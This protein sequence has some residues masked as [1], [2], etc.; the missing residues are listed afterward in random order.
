MSDHPEESD[1][2]N[3]SHAY[4]HA[5]HAV[6]RAVPHRLD[7]TDAPRWP[8]NPQRPAP[9]RPI[10][11]V[12]THTHRVESPTKSAFKF[13]F[14]FAAGVWTFRVLVLVVVWTILAIVVGSLV[15]RAFPS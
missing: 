12:V 14:G 1:F 4:E 7:V 6:D 15:M 10:Q 8:A 5:E 13:G 11:H 9:A 2:S 3:A